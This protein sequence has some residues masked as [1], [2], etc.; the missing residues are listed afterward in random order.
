MEQGDSEIKG[1]LVRDSP[2]GTVSCC[3]L[4]KA[5]PFILCSVLFQQ[6]KTGNCPDMTETMFTGT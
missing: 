5:I 3:V 2:D 6:R 1:S 4:V